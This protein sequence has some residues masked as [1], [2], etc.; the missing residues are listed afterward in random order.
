MISGG[1][2]GPH[3][4]DN[5]QR[6]LYQP[7][8][9]SPKACKRKPQQVLVPKTMVAARRLSDGDNLRWEECQAT[10][11]CPKIRSLKKTTLPHVTTRWV[12]KTL[13]Q[14]QGYYEGST[15][16]WLPKERSEAASP[17]K[18]ISTQYAK[19]KSSQATPQ[20]IKG[21]SY[22]WRPIIKKQNEKLQEATNE[23]KQ[24]Q[25]SR[26]T[27]NPTKASRPSVAYKGKWVPKLIARAEKCSL[28]EDQA[29][30]SSIIIAKDTTSVIN[31]G[32]TNP[33]STPTRLSNSTSGSEFN[34]LNIKER[35]LLLQFQLF[36]MT[37]IRHSFFSK[38][39]FYKS[40][41][42]AAA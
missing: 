10:K 34:H 22:Q 15:R 31:W 8:Y 29:S 27:K 6:K 1:S 19:L 25:Q 35:A 16:L 14:A 33:A 26:A 41:Q 32:V 42:V 36:G 9:P 7:K 28:V 39:G 20:F 4:R 11:Q 13:L 40:S 17:S 38:D 2:Y 12:P 24:P 5:Q 3:Q 21:N 30:T 23:A 37:S 18:A